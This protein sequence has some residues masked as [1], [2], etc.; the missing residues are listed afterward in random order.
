VVKPWQFAQQD[1]ILKKDNTY[2]IRNTID[3]IVYSFECEGK[4]KTENRK[5]NMLRIDKEPIGRSVFE[6][7]NL[8]KIDESYKDKHLKIIIKAIDR[9]GCSENAQKEI[10]L[11]VV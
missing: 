1:Y 9:Y 4:V 7:Y 3:E 11:D 8:F 2:E 6:F 5:L 10:E